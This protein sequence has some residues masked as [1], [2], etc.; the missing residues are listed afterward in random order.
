MANKKNIYWACQIFGWTFFTALNL[1]FFKLNNSTNLIDILNYLIW[2]PVGISLTHVYKLLIIK[3]NALKFN[4]IKQI[5]FVIVAGFIKAFLFFVL[6]V[7]IAKVFGIITYKIN[8]VAALSN[9]FS[10]SVIFI[11]WSL[12][13]FGFHFFD[14][15]KKTEIQNLKLEAASK[16]GE[17]NKLKSQLNPHFM[18]NSMNSIRALID[19]DPKKAKVAVTQLSNILRS[20]LMM[21]K[22]KLISFQDELALVKDYLELEHIRF[23]ERLRY[24]FEIDNQTLN[25]SVPP[26]MI[27]TLVENGIKHGIS[28]FAEGGEITLKAKKINS[29]LLVEIINSGQLDLSSQSDTGFG[30]ENT[31]NRL[32][33]LFGNNASFSIQNLDNQHVISTLKI[34]Y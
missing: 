28:K 27:Q 18:F 4:V 1:I 20:T 14:N 23:E 33:L 24:S 30:I 17:L 16:E 15:Y 13:Y 9:I 22:N 29:E 32:Q 5:P 31:T 10:L 3:F 6:T 25:L 34:N 12:I 8:L 11:L 26:M 19:E 2:L 21:H 7:G